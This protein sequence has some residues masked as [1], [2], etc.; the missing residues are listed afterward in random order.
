MLALNRQKQ[1]VKI[2]KKTHVATVSE[3]ASKFDVHEA[4]IRRDLSALERGGLVHRTHGGV[5]LNEDVSSEPS[6][7]ERETA[8]YQ[9]KQRIGAAASEMVENGDNI[10]L[11]SGTTT[12]HVA[13]SIIDKENLTVI[14]NDINI[15][16]KL[17]SANSIKVIVTGGQ[18]FPDSFMLNGMI[19]DE[20]LSTLHVH[21]AFIA[22]PALH[23]GKGLTH[24]DEQLVP[25]KR[26]MIRAAK[27]IIV[28]ADHTKI[29][30]ISLHKIAEP[31]Q[32]NDLI[33]GQEIE[34][35][36]LNKW[37]DT[38]TVVHLA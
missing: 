36:Y 3:L 1:I 13:E 32:I 12:L 22:T 5:V 11:D 4:T 29:G 27:E 31:K 24:F 9:E 30:G 34:E 10:I 8:Q 26:G 38:D 16:A 37:Q 6:F 18:L 25:A 7:H 19:T 23:H 33:T 14:T 15:A 21:K 17:K 35:S 20:V 28:V 2:V